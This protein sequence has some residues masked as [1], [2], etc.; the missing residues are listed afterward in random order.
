MKIFRSAALAA[1]ALAA[2]ATAT[3]ASAATI[4]LNG[5][6]S[7]SNPS[8]RRG[9]TVAAQY[10]ENMLLN[11]TTVKLNVGFASLAPG[12]L[13]QAGSTRT[14][15][16]V[17]T[18]YSALIANANSAL[19]VAAITSLGTQI[20]TGY[21]YSVNALV[22]SLDDVNVTIN[23]NNGSYN[24]AVL[25]EN[26]AVLK[27]MSVT[28]YTGVDAGI[29]FN[30]DV[31]FDFN[32][33][34]G[35]AA[36]RADF[37]GVAIHEM[38]HALGFTSGVDFY[39]I[40]ACPAGPGCGLIPNADAVFDDNSWMRTLDLFRYSSE[41]QLD[42]TVGTPSYF[43]IDNGATE[44]NGEASFSS[45]SYNGDGFQAS[46]WQAPR[47][48]VNPNFFT[49]ATTNRLG[50]MNPYLCDG[51]AGEVEG[52]DIAALDAIGWNTRVDA[53]ANPNYRASSGDIF[54]QFAPVPE[55]GTWAM[56]ILGF[57]L[58][59]GALRRRCKSQLSFA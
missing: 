30:S 24:N 4:V 39:D 10:W 8:A 33:V 3:P 22:S 13:A 17:T 28:G 58:V 43:S 25:Y 35:I 38:G 26:T 49:C 31:A 9:Y 16:L 42:W 59:G 32:P 48:T 47:S 45:G 51:Q 11:N 29:T 5:L 18:A 57:G 44:F 15:V 46:H 56:M 54:A 19:D 34:N 23:D 14:D 6:E 50:I 37:V 7:I 27:A 1:S 2:V 53:L 36:G 40:Y 12:V 41:G 21:G 20:A 52:H 55:P